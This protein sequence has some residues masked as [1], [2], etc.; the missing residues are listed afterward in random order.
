MEGSDVREEVSEDAQLRRPQ[1]GYA[2]VHIESFVFESM[3][4]QRCCD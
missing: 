2:V 4:G 3:D 1:G